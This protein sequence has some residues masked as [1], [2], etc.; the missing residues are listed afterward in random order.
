MPSPKRVSGYVVTAAWKLDWLAA[1]RWVTD[2]QMFEQ[3]LN[4]PAVL[5][6]KE[7]NLAL[8]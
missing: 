5:G 1:Y 4:F 3:M 6:F 2:L 7:L 8:S